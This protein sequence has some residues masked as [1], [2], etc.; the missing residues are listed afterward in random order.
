[1]RTVIGL[2]VAGE[3]QDSDAFNELLEDVK[4]DVREFVVSAIG[5]IQ[6]MAAEVGKLSGRDT[7]AVLHDWA[8]M[9]AE[10]EAGLPEPKEPDEG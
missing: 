2:A 6:Q 10:G 1:M 5:T 7:L 9:A 4:A 3:K 8:M